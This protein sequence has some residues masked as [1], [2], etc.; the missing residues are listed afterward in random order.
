MPQQ[1]QDYLVNIKTFQ[2]YLDHIVNSIESDRYHEDTI[3]KL[4]ESINIYYKNINESDTEESD[5]YE[6]YTSKLKN[7]N[8]IEFIESDESDSDTSIHGTK[9]SSDGSDS[10]SDSDSD[11]SGINSSGIDYSNIFTNN[12]KKVKSVNTIDKY[13]DDFINTKIDNSDVYFYNKHPEF[14]TRFN[15]FVNT[16]ECY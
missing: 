4:S 12:T 7:D 9:Q 2:T 8:D 16:I 5:T 13:L 1:I 11:S 14:I 3:K 10:D 15:R 6:S